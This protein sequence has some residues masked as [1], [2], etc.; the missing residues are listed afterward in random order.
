MN[1]IRAMGIFVVITAL[2]TAIQAVAQSPSP[3][4]KP[5]TGTTSKTATG[6]HATPAPNAAALTPNPEPKVQAISGFVSLAT[7][8]EK[9]IDVRS[10]V[11]KDWMDRLNWVLTAILV[12]IGA[13]GVRYAKKTLRVIQGQLTEIQ[14]AGKQTDQMVKHAGIQAEAAKTSAEA[15]IHSERAWVVIDKVYPP[16]LMVQLYGLSGGGANQ[17]LFDI[18]NVGRTVARLGTLR[19][20]WRVLPR[21]S[22]LP[23]VPDL[24]PIEGESTDLVPAH[25]RVLAPGETVDGLAAPIYEVFDDE[26]IKNIKN[27]S[28]ILWVYG[29]I[30]YFDFAGQERVMHFCYRYLSMI[31]LSWNGE[32]KFVSAGPLQYQVHT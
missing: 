30:K 4:A 1:S 17:F 29:R 11:V 2:G 9:P 28:M 18:K 23:D 21:N 19:T 5:G 10:D 15:L 13:L 20:M 27:G 26:K 31:D 22:G 32:D 16:K 14:A 12:V 24:G 25:G 7:S 6:T 8:K 3:P